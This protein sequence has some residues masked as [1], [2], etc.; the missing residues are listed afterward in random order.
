MVNLRYSL[1]IGSGLFVKAPRQELIDADAW[2]ASCD[3]FEDCLETGI[4]FDTVEFA[5]LD[6]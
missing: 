1:C 6:Q 5:G 4:G 3:G 2:M